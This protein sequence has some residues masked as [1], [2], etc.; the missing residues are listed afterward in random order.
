MEWAQKYSPLTPKNYLGIKSN[1]RM[2][3]NF[4]ERWLEKQP[5]KNAI[6]LYG[7]P[8]NGKTSL[9]YCLEEEY[10]LSIIEINASNHRNTSDIKKLFHKTG[11]KAFDY[12]QTVMLLDEVD[13]L[14]AWQIL[15]ELIE[16]T[17]CPIVM[18]CNDIDKVDYDVL[19]D[20]MTLEI[21]Y[22]PEEHVAQRLL[23]ILRAEDNAGRIIDYDALSIAKLR[24]IAAQCGSVRSAIS[25]LEMMVISENYDRIIITDIDYSEREQIRRLFS[26]QQVNCDLTPDTIKKWAIKNNIK[27]HSLDKLISMAR[28]YPNFSKIVKE[29]SLTLRGSVKS[30]KT[31]YFTDFKRTKKVKKEPKIKFKAKADKPTEIVRKKLTENKTFESDALW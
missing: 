18:T 29:Y 8:G 11:I 19:K 25:T 6:I 23:S 3:T 28:I 22:P 21:T 7:E 27:I 26:G 10:N 5:L 17:R 9:L 20:C 12:K 14:S 31:P 2:M 15:G 30:L 24:D 16:H 1:L 13:G 4:L